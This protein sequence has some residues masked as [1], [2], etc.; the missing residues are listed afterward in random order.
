MNVFDVRKEYPVRIE[1]ILFSDSV[2]QNQNYDI[3]RE[4]RPY[5]NCEGFIAVY[6][7]DSQSV[8]IESAE[9]ARNLQKALDKA[10][11]LG[12]LK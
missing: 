7:G 10:I 5:W 3:A 11:E 4:L 9:H 6:C 2:A 8:L 12:W 1:K